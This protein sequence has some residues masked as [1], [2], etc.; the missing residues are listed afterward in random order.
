MKRLLFRL[1]LAP[2][3]GR[4][5]PDSWKPFF[6]S[7]DPASVRGGILGHHHDERCVAFE[8][9]QAAALGMKVGV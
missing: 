8:A 6:R 2:P 4:K 7:V 3:D 9:R 5:L 1:W